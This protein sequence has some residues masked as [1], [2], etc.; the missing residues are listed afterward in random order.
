MAVAVI[1]IPAAEEL[2]VL[3][4]AA[5]VAMSP[6][7]K[8]AGKALADGIAHM[9]DAIKEKLSESEPKAAEPCPE[10]KAKESD[11][12]KPEPGEAPR[13]EDLKGKSPEEVDRIMKERGWPSEPTREGEGSGVRYPNP[14]KPGEQVRVMPGKATDPNP[15]KQGPYG[16][17]SQGGKVSDPIPLKGNP[18]LR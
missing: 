15:V 11:G 16:R 8:E 12:K 1:A 7:V 14:S 18:T 9:A 10:D 3:V 4:G 2:A 6:M 5:I 17:I 13:P